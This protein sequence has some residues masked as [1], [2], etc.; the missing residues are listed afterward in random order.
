MTEITSREMREVR[1]TMQVVLQDP[2]ASLNPRMTAGAI[3]EE[4]LRIHRIGARESRRARVN[5]LMSV[6]GLGPQYL[7]RRPGIFPEA[8]DS[9]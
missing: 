4:P 9:D 7:D 8:S 5:E 6:V 1:R 2:Y 3:L